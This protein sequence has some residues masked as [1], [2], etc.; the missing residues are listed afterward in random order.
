MMSQREFELF[1]LKTIKQIKSEVIPYKTNFTKIRIGDS[2]DGGYVICDG[3][4]S[5][6]LYSY[7]C[8]DN[9]KFENAY[10]N[11]FKKDC[12]VYDHTVSGITDKPDFI[13]FFKQGVSHETTHDCDTI[14]NQIARNGHV[15]CSQMFA[16]IDIEGCEWNILRSSE[17]LKE[18]SQVIIEFH[19]P[20]V[21][22]ILNW[23][24]CILETLQ[25]MNKHFVC[26]HVHGNNSPLQ[27]WVDHDFPRIYECTYV[28][29]DLVTHAEI[30]YQKYPMADIDTPNASDRPDLPLTW[31]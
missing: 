26:V 14:D 13:H 11:K 18:F 4:P 24:T 12:W 20:P 17:K 10:Y 15:D 22:D 7:G 29:R 6:G 19:T 8:D 21:N 23:S 9:I 31:W 3:I 2:G 5:S 30:D 1:F 28:R 27:P 25:Y 16:Q